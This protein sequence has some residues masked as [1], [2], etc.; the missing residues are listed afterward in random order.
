[1]FRDTLHT[2]YR[3]STKAKFARKK[4]NKGASRRASDSTETSLSNSIRSSSSSTSQ[5][6]NKTYNSSLAEETFGAVEKN[7]S[8][9]AQQGLLMQAPGGASKNFND[10]CSLL[11][12]YLQLGAARPVNFSQTIPFP[13]SVLSSHVGRAGMDDFPDDISEIFEDV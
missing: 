5:G 1:M 6:S 13:S 7:A 9:A 4:A 8:S 10:Y 12:S 3:S 11:S 2:Q